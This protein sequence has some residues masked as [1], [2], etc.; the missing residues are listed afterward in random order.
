MNPGITA[1]TWTPGARSSARRLSLQIA[2]AAFEAEYAPTPGRPMR[3]AVLATLTIALGAEA[4]SSGSSAS[5]SR[6]WASKLSSIVLRTSACPV[7]AN[8]PRP[9]APALLT[10]RSS[11]PPWRRSR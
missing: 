5:T 4:R 8:V 10:S 2:S 6:T 9:P 7:A 1:P 11:R 3:P